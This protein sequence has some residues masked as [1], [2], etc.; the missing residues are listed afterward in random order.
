MAADRHLIDLDL[1]EP[2]WDSFFL[3]APLVVI[4]TVEQDGT[5]DFAPKHMAGPMSWQNL[6]GFVCSPEHSTYR[7]LT[8]TCEFTV[9]YPGPDAVVLASLAAAPRLDDASK[10]SLAVLPTIAASVVE[11]PMLADAA[12]YLEC[13]LE[14]TVDDLAGN[15]LVIGTIVAARVDASA[16]RDPDRDDA[17]VLAASPLLAFLPPAFFTSISRGNSFPFHL[18][19]RR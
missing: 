18:G 19:W 7:N 5:A 13:R 12:L 17:D 8:R 3:V 16:R 4:G 6:F 15:S 9:S 11:P 2:I 14:R 1:S 10:P